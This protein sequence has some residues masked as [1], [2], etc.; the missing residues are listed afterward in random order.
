[1]NCFIKTNRMVTTALVMVFAIFILSLNSCNLFTTDSTY[2]LT[3][4]ML[5][6]CSGEPYKNYSLTFYIPGNGLGQKKTVLGTV[7][8]DEKGSFILPNIPSNRS[9]NIHLK[10]TIDANYVTTWGNFTIPDSVNI[11]EDGAVYDLGD[12]YGV[13]TK[14]SL[15]KISIDPGSFD[16]WDTLYIGFGINHYSTIYPIPNEYLYDYSS[17]GSNIRVSSV[18]KELSRIWGVKKAIYQNSFVQNTSN[19]YIKLHTIKSIV[20]TC[21]YPDTTY[22]HIP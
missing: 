21:T 18:K 2:S 14:K 9:G 5:K 7:S 4:R 8:T 17:N 13:Y 22:Y 3:G 6:D 16:I 10:H 11:Y 15:I 1:M 19:E 12:Y 20:T